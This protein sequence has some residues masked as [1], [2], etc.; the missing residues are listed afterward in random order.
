MRFILIVLMALPLAGCLITTYAEDRAALAA[1]D[2]AEC[3]SYGAQPGSSTYVECRAARASAHEMASATEDAAPRSG[4]APIP[5]A[6]YP[7]P[8]PVHCTTTGRFTNCF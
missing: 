1:K 2:D 4:P 8:P 3:R 6:S 7:P 5:Q